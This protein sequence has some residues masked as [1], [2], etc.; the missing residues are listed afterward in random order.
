MSR[1][2]VRSY[3]L[4]WLL[5]LRGRGCAATPTGPA[6]VITALATQ[7]KTYTSQ[8]TVAYF[9]PVNCTLTFDQDVV[10]FEQSSLTASPHANILNWVEVNASIYEF[11]VTSSQNGEVSLHVALEAVQ[12]TAGERN[13]EQ[14]A[15]FTFEYYDAPPTVA[16]KL[17]A[18]GADRTDRVANRAYLVF[19]S[20]VVFNGALHVSESSL[21]F[22]PALAITDFRNLNSTTFSFR[23]N[24]DKN[25]SASVE[26]VEPNE[27]DPANLTV[28]LTKFPCS[29]CNRTQLCRS[30]TDYPPSSETHLEFP[31]EVTLA[32]VPEVALGQRTFPV[33]YDTLWPAVTMEVAGDPTCQGTVGRQPADCTCLIRSPTS[34]TGPFFLTVTWSE[35]MER[36]LAVQPVITPAGSHSLDV[37]ILSSSSY[38]LRVT[39]AGT[40]TYW[41]TIN[42]TVETSDLAGNNNDFNRYPWTQTDGSV[43]LVYSF[44]PPVPGTVTFAYSRPQELYEY[45]ATAATVMASPTIPSLGVSWADF[46]TATR[47][48]LWINWGVNMSWPM[49][50]DLTTESHYFPEFRAQLGVEYVFSIRAWNV[51]DESMVVTRTFLHPQ[52]DVVAD[53]TYSTLSLPT[54]MSPTQ[55]NVSFHAMIKRQSFLAMNPLKVLSFRTMDREQGSQDPCL[56]NS[57]LLRCTLVNFH[58]DV[59]NTNF[60]VFRQP[61]RLQFTFGR[62]GWQDGYFRPQL[63]YW[64][65]ISQKWRPAFDTC[66]SETA[67]ER[68]NDLHRIYA[69]SFCHLTQF[70]IF[71]VP[72]TSVITT[73]AA[74]RVDRPGSYES[75]LFFVI[76]VVVVVF[77]LLLCGALCR[78]K[79]VGKKAD[80][81]HKEL[82]IRPLTDRIPRK[83]RVSVKTESR[84]L[85]P[86]VLPGNS[87]DSNDSIV[88]VEDYC[89]DEPPLENNR[90]DPHLGEEDARLLPALP[91]PV[92]ADDVSTLSS[93]QPS[94]EASPRASPRGSMGSLDTLTVPVLPDR[95]QPLMLED[96]AREL[97]EAAVTRG[98]PRGPPPRL[99]PPSAPPPASNVVSNEVLPN[100]GAVSNEVL[101]IQ[102]SDGVYA[103][104]GV[105]DSDLQIVELEEL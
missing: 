68:W 31:F 52:I 55:S 38:R 67:Y 37:T 6:G 79:L 62:Q 33:I 12:G 105:P 13:S 96:I 46:Q 75:P 86:Q 64:E 89:D 70:A 43:Y 77:M 29:G 19:S 71:E 87:N 2:P 40:G 44:G 53:G 61:I 78:G 102:D 91:P 72:L 34:C 54:L 95:P 97:P 57:P 56:A 59:P 88:F 17:D 47:Y 35:P 76:L 36:L 103:V 85:R 45:Q 22:S 65:A 21:S 90:G 66:P 84:T 49:L 3:V 7:T 16:L 27:P 9:E 60:V 83:R 104:P 25:S 32:A 50:R 48:D 74:P 73:T 100:G 69:V 26:C 20:P 58:V 92:I 80:L 30:Y 4:L 11:Q 41:I 93:G 15:N 18:F 98:P 82:G 23:F 51:W 94:R 63:R 101:P 8:V 81:I 99:P 28:N 5:T 1:C 10:G 24:V 14:T 39:P 42:G